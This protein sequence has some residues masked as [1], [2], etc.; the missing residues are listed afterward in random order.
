MSR[1]RKKVLSD[2][3]TRWYPLT[4]VDGK[5]TPLGGFRTKTNAQAALK[6]AE[7]EVASGTY[8]KEEPPKFGELAHKWLNDVARHRVKPSTLARYTVDVD[9][10]LCPYFGA[11]K[12]T[13]INAEKIDTF[14]SE[15]IDAGSS[16]RSLNS[17]LKQLGAIMKYALRLNYISRNPMDHVGMV[18][19]AVDE[20][21]FFTAPEVVRLLDAVPPE[22]YALFATAVLS[23]VREGEL[24][25]LRWMDFDPAMNALYVRRTYHPDWGF[26]APKSRAG[27]RAV[28]MSPELANILITHR[29][30]T[31]YNEGDDLIFPN[32]V[33]KPMDYHNITG[34]VFNQALDQAAL[35]RIR[36]HDL[37]HTYA[38]LCISENVNFKWLQRQMG[39]ASITTTMDTYGH[40]MPEVEEKLGGKL[41][42]LLFDKKV[43]PFK[44]KA[45]GKG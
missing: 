18:K 11:M 35:R 19:V 13:S 16:P 41:D 37:R 42:S 26:T 21:D 9:R 22:H 23:G 43:V 6:K 7:A 33:G 20:M 29:N 2:G 1:I 15:K 24:L 14:K 45:S 27:S 32:Q 5:E 40:I 39:H 38:A 25:A 28:Q 8:G 36:F 17:M 30:N 10:H 31:P 34:R 3:K 12:L 44:K 4:M